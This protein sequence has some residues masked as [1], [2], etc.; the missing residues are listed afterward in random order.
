MTIPILFAKFKNCYGSPEIAPSAPFRHP[1]WVPNTFLEQGSLQS[2]VKTVVENWLNRQDGFL[3][4]RVKQISRLLDMSSK[5]PEEENLP[6]LMDYVPEFFQRKCEEELNETPERKQTALQELRSMLQKNQTTSGIDFLEDFL[7]QYL[8]RHK[9]KTKPAMKMVENS[10]DI[11]RNHNYL[12]QS[13]P[14]KYFLLRSSTKWWRVL[15]KRCPDGCTIL[16]VQVG[17]WNPDEFPFELYKKMVAMIFLQILRDP[18]TQINGIKF[19]QDFKGTSFQH[20]KY[21]TPQTMYL[22]YQCTINSIPGRYKAFH[23]LN[24]SIFLKTAWTIVK[25]FLSQKMRSRE[26]YENDRDR[27]DQMIEGRSK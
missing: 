24:E 27:R 13:I 19:I 6:F 9:Y 10:V 25:P 17:L 14:D 23:C 3:P 2:N 5:P 20:L 16:L 15:P 12:I 22:F 1:I 4:S 8:R 7:V 26:M 21:A 18:M 11:Y